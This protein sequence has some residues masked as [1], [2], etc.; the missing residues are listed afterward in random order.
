MHP[1]MRASLILVLVSFYLCRVSGRKLI[2]VDDKN[3]PHACDSLRNKDVSN[4]SCDSLQKV[5]R[6]VADSGNVAGNNS[7]DYVEIQISE[8]HYELTEQVAIEQNIVLR[9]KTVESVQ[10]TFNGLILNDSFHAIL[11]RSVEH[12]TV[13]GISFEGIQGIIVFENVTRVSISNSSFR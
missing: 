4:F 3:G 1:Q 6:F 8:G 11:I 5:L 13:E 7:Y 12:A 9:A 2:Q 10:V